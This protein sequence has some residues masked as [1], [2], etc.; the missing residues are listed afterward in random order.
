MNI[1]TK[2]NIG[3]KSAL[4]GASLIWGS[5]FLIVKTSMDVMDPHVLLGLRFMTGCLLLV[6]IF[7]KK[8]KALNMD[9]LKKGAIIGICLFLG[10]SLQTIGITGTTPGK[11][12]FLTAIYCVI[13]PFLYWIVDKHKPDIYNYTAAIISIVGIGLVSLNGAFKIEYGDAFTLAG[14]IFFAA[15]MVAVAKYSKDKEPVLI[16]ILQ[17]FYAAVFSWIIAFLFE[18]MPKSINMET[19]NGLLYL[20]VFATMI[21]LLLQNIGQKYTK[22]APASIILSLEAVFGVLFS[23]IFYKEEI[24]PKLL[25]G[26]F[27]IFVAIIISETKLY[28]LKK[29]RKSLELILEESNKY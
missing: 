20:S 4:F 21:A 8:L 12:A 15:H 24:T 7:Y 3:A 29:D 1:E 16:T 17:F 6:I 5:S 26:F 23:V 14:G 27:L 13:V 9:Y 25:L 22:P 2:R 18:D 19:I 11:N 28:F 10:Y